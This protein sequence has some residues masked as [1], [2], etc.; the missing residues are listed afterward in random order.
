MCSLYTIVIDWVGYKILIFFPD[1][2]TLSFYG[3]NV[4][5]KYEYEVYN[6]V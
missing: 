2:R 1:V 6:T 5:E 4:K 3:S